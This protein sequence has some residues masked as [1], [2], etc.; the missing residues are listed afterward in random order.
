MFN[1]LLA[2]D[3]MGGGASA[4]ADMPIKSDNEYSGATTALIIIAVF[5]LFVWIGIRYFKYKN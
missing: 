2:I 3:I 4:P 1:W 5:C